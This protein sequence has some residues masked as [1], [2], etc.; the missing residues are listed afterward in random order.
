MQTFLFFSDLLV[1]MPFLPYCLQ[2]KQKKCLLTNRYI[3]Q[4]WVITHYAPGAMLGTSKLM[5][6]ISEVS[7]DSQEFVLLPGAYMTKRPQV[8][9][10]CYSFAV[11]E[12][13]SQTSCTLL[14][15]WF[16][17][18]CSKVETFI[19]YIPSARL[20]NLLWRSASQCTLMQ[21][22]SSRCLQPEGPH[23][24]TVIL[25]NRAFCQ[26]HV[27]LCVLS[28]PLPEMRPQEDISRATEHRHFPSGS[29]QR[30]FNI[31]G[32]KLGTW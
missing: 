9:S 20:L 4:H 18:I 12:R 11:R 7:S 31:G 24:G 2:K 15:G 19:S 29:V 22:W 6:E 14:T 26:N 25:S 28:A 10:S 23:G 1:L 17:S 30:S 3:W 16:Q 32:L 5:W 8:F 21:K 13:S 27:P